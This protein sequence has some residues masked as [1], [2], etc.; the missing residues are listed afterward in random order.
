M[1]L[2]YIKIILIICEQLS[3]SDQD[4]DPMANNYLYSFLPFL[5]RILIDYSKTNINE[6][7]E[8]KI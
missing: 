4:K 1:L 5:E 3:I 6:D 7:I 8:I 2:T